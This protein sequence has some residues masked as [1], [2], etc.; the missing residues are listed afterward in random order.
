MNTAR[1]TRSELTAYLDL[2]AAADATRA[3]TAA[4]E[5]QVQARRIAGR[6]AEERARQR[7]TVRA[8]GIVAAVFVVIPFALQFI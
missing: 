2:K 6:V 1:L 4:H 7:R 5:L 8:L 3:A